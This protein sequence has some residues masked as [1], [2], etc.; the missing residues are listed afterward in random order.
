MLMKF[1]DQLDDST[2]TVAAIE[3]P[4]LTR[5]LYKTALEIAK[6]ARIV[7]IDC[8][9]VLIHV[10][11]MEYSEGF[12]RYKITLFR[13]RDFKRYVVKDGFTNLREVPGYK[14]V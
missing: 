3:A 2:L 6:E 8:G 9:E 1:K 5:R 12:Y 4:K 11:F 14:E 7:S 10:I 13:A